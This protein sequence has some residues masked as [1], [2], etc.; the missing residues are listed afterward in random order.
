MS[1]FITLSRI[2]VDFLMESLTCPFG[3]ILSSVLCPAGYL[4][5]PDYFRCLSIP[6]QYIMFVQ[7]VVQSAL[8]AAGIKSRH[9]GGAIPDISRH[10]EVKK[11]RVGALG[12]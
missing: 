3:I 12:P 1:F 5:R 6:D 10:H 2:S 8:S 11:I 4:C 9:H 7:V